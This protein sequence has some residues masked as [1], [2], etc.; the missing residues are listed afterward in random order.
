MFGL[1]NSGSHASRV[2]HAVDVV[3]AA[4]VEADEA[5]AERGADLHQLEHRLEL[6][7][8]HV[9]L[10]R[11]DRQ[12]EMLLER[13]QDVVPE[14]RFLGRLNLRQVE[15]QRRAGLAAAASGCCAT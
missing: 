11:A 8:E 14:R 5:R 4:G 12:A 15:H 2:G 1:T 7:D 6:L 3:P 13:G 10:D 9:G